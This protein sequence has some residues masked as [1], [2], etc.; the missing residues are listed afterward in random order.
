MICYYVYYNLKNKIL[1]Q[2]L[3]KISKKIIM[4]KYNTKIF[5]YLIFFNSYLNYSKY[6]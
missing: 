6:S 5:I 2:I 1:F 3:I 4:K